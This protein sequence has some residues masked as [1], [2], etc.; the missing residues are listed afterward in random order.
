MCTRQGSVETMSSTTKATLGSPATLRNLSVF[1]SAI[2][3]IST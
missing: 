3:P 2:P 1:A